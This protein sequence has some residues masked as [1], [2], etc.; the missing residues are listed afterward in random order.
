MFGLT[1]LIVGAV[2]G[3][4]AK[5]IKWGLIALAAV[6]CMGV[7]AR[8][9]HSYDKIAYERLENRLTAKQQELDTFKQ[10]V[11]DNGKLAERQKALQ[12]AA[13]QRN[14]ERADEE[15]K[16]RSAARAVQLKRLRDANSTPGRFVPAASAVA[17]S[18]DETCYDSAKLDR[19]LRE[20]SDRAAELIGE[21]AE[22]QD[23]IGTVR[24][25]DEDRLRAAS[26]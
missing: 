20:F 24:Q 18:A 17:T 13:D 8:L 15:E 6:V 11:A 14:K 23:D 19:A 22:A 26:P 10:Q 16:R 25:W 3:P 21:G 9:M 12:I 5:L 4:Y 7:G 2:G 1:G